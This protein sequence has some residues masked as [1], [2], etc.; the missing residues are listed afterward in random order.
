[1]E[2]KNCTYHQ[3]DYNNLG[4]GNRFLPSEPR[5]GD[6]ASCNLATIMERQTKSERTTTQLRRMLLQELS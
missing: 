2:I 1:M 4:N 6:H 3:L 5:F